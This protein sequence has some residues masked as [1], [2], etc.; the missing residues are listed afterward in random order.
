[1]TKSEIIRELKE[2][3]DKLAYESTLLPKNVFLNY[4]ADESTSPDEYLYIEAKG[5]S[6]VEGYS[7]KWLREHLTFN[8]THPCDWVKIH[9]YNK[10]WRAWTGAS[11]GDA[12]WDD[13]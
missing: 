5:D 7:V 11:I 10:R 2:L 3:I 9:T 4:L 12:P 8:P 6:E 1:M 13:D